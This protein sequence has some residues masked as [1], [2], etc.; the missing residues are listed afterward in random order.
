MLRG[1]IGSGCLLL[2]LACGPRIIRITPLVGEEGDQ[3]TIEGDEMGSA[4][5]VTFEGKPPGTGPVSTTTLQQ[6][7]ATGVNTWV[8]AGAKSGPITVDTPR[9][10]ATS[11]FDFTVVGGTF[12]ESGN[13]TSKGKAD[14]VDDMEKVIVGSLGPG[15][16]QDW[17][18]VRAGSKPGPI[19]GHLVTLQITAT[20]MGKSGRIELAIWDAQKDEIIAVDAGVDPRVWVVTTAVNVWVQVRNALATI[21]GNPV[22]YE[23][24]VG[25]TPLIEETECND[26][27]GFAAPFDFAGIGRRSY[28]IN[29]Y[30]PDPKPSDPCPKNAAVDLYA[31]PK[32]EDKETVSVLVFGAELPDADNQH[33]F[34]IEVLDSSGATA[35]EAVGNYLAA[36]LTFIVDKNQHNLSG[37]W[38]VRISS[39]PQPPPHSGP[40]DPPHHTLHQY[41]VMASS[42]I[43]FPPPP[44]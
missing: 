23:V 14:K 9:G 28:M 1:L 31:L 34:R 35:G 4:T 38:R 15:N 13:N 8:P 25:R 22:G 16:T 37:D 12:M 26:V 40:G 44:P 17:Y 20:T 42:E 3:V 33:N 36:S 39:H 29:Y 5:Q 6:V 7:S 43:P 41:T 11:P 18:R 24:S 27:E 21:G 10:S 32:P 2:V 19:Y 30:V